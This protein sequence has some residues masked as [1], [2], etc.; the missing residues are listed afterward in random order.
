MYYFTHV[1]MVILTYMVMCFTYVTFVYE[2]VTY[3][4]FTNVKPIF[5]LHVKQSNNPLGYHAA[6]ITIIIIQIYGIHGLQKSPIDDDAV[7]VM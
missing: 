6:L 1:K 3:E 2:N 5:I 4:S 7:D